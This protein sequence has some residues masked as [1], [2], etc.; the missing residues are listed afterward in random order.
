MI[1]NII[2]KNIKRKKVQMWSVY[3]LRILSWIELFWTQPLLFLYPYKIIIKLFKSLKV[4]SIKI[5]SSHFL[6]KFDRTQKVKNGG[7]KD[8]Y[9]LIYFLSNQTKDFTYFIFSHIS[10]NPPNQPNKVQG[11]GSSQK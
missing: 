10:T 8:S 7:P 5:Y 9:S 6:S 11:L 4:I 2:L 3:G 1:K